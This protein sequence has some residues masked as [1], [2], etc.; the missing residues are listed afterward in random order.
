VAV[1]FGRIDAEALQDVYADLLLAGIDRVRLE[2]SDQLVLA[3]TAA[4]HAHV[5]E[6]GLV[7]DA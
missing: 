3:N 7:V 5:D 2:S 6:P 4:A 1:A